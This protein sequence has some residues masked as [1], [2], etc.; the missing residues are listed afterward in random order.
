MKFVLADKSQLDKYALKENTVLEGTPVAPTPNDENDSK[1][2]ATTE[3]VQ[4][5]VECAVYIDTSA[6]GI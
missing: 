4:N 3:F 5:L 6:S 2:I 1:Q